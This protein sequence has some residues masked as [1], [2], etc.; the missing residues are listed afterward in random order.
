[1]LITQPPPDAEV[2]DDLISYSN[3]RMSRDTDYETDLEMDYDGRI[4]VITYNAMFLIS[5][6]KKF[7]FI[8]LFI[9][10]HSLPFI[11]LS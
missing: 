8:I 11:R 2:D 5:C 10:K 7:F 4:I 3:G 6:Q 9:T 1:V